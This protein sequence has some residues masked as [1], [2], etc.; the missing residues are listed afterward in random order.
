MGTETAINPLV[1]LFPYILI[2]GIFYL[3]VIKPQKQKQVEFQ[4]MLADLKKNDA[5]VTTGGIHGTIVN[6]KETTLTV[7]IDDNVKIEIDRNA[8]ARIEKKNP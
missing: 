6:L 3:L 1:M 5:I 2:F 7:R 4:K 8:V